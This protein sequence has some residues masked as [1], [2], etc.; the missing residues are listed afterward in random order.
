MLRSAAVRPIASSTE[1]QIVASIERLYPRL[2]RFARFCLEPDEA[3][4]ATASALERI[5]RM[6]GRY[7]PERGSI[8]GWLYTVGVNAIRDEARRVRRRPRTVALDDLELGGAPA[9]QLGQLGDVR[10]AMARLSSLD[11]EL[12]ALRFALELSND[13]IGRVV[14]RSTGATAT[15]LHRALRRLRRLL[16]EDSNHDRR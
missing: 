6:R 16:E 15:A 11:A 13:E 9:T 5:W 8:D 1:Q 4:D 2:F 7:R 12:I 14:G 3:E 10:E